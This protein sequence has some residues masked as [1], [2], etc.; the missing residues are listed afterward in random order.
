VRQ[1]GFQDGLARAAKPP[2][3]LPADAYPSVTDAW[4][5]SACARPDAAAADWLGRPV[6]GVGKLAA[7]APD[8]PGPDAQ[9]RPQVLTRDLQAGPALRAPCTPDAVQSVARSFVAAVLTA[10]QARPALL[11][12]PP[13][14]G[15]VAGARRFAV[16]PLL[17]LPGSRGPL[18]PPALEPPVAEP[19]EP[20]EL[21][22]LGTGKEPAAQER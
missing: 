7:L 9:W 13:L 15:T 10:A 4:D 12:E 19:P 1:A 21:P 8:V 3:L 6:A 5:A 20:R 17:A 16:M 2:A 22:E 11:D 18:G 14:S